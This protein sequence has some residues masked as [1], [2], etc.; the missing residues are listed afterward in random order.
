MYI[1]IIYY[2]D[3]PIYIYICVCVC[4]C[5]FMCVLIYTHIYR[6]LGRHI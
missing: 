4:V 3:T 2:M 6:V 1:A 5:V